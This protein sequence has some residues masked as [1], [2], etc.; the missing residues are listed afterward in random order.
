MKLSI[1]VLLCLFL[2]PAL[3]NAQGGWIRQYY[4]NLT[5]LHKI[6][7]APNGDNF[8]SGIDYR[9]GIPAHF[10][11][12][13]HDADGNLLWEKSHRLS[14]QNGFFNFFLTA[15]PLNGFVT[16][17]AMTVE[18]GNLN[19]NTAAMIAVNDNGDTLWSYVPTPN[20]ESYIF[21]AVYDTD[22]N[23]VV[24]SSIRSS[25]DLVLRPIITK[26]NAQNGEIIWTK[27]INE[28]CNQGSM[29]IQKMPNGFAISWFGSNNYH[30]VAFNTDGDE[31]WH[32]IF[33]LEYDFNVK[34]EG[35]FRLFRYAVA[36]SLQIIEYDLNGN[37]TKEGVAQ[38]PYITLSIPVDS[39]FVV[40]GETQ[41]SL[42]LKQFNADYQ[43]VN[44]LSILENFQS[45]I[46]MGQSLKDGYEMP[47][48][49]FTLLLGT[50]LLRI[51][52]N[53]TLQP[54]TLTGKIF[55]DKSNDC[56]E[57][58]GEL[59]LKNSIVTAKNLTDGLVWATTTDSA[60]VY[61]LKLT[62]GNFEINAVA[63]FPKIGYW[64]NCPPITISSDLVGDTTLLDPIGL[65]T[66]VDCPL[67]NVQMC[68]GLFRPCSTSVVTLKVLNE[69]TLVENQ[70]MVTLSHSPLLTYESS[71]IPL[72]NQ[73]GNTLF[74]DI[75][76][77][78]SLSDTSFNVNFFVDC[79]AQLG[80]TACLT[81]SVTPD[82]LCIEPENWDGA[83]LQITSY[84]E[85]DTVK[86]LV[87]NKG[88]GG[89][90]EVSELI[91]IEDYIIFR[92]SP[93]QLGSGQD[94][95]ITQPNPDGKTYYASI[96]QTDNFPG[97]IIASAGEDYCGGGGIPG[98]L[99]NYPML[100]GSPF[101]TRYCGEIS[102]AFD[103]NDK[104]GFPLGYGNS[105]YIDRGI[106]IDYRI[107]FQ[108]TG[109]DTA[110]T[111]IV[112]D[113]LPTTLDVTTLRIGASSHPFTWEFTGQST[114]KFRFDHILLPDSTTNEP[115]SHGFV[116]FKISPKTEIP[117]GTLIE[118]R[119]AIYFDYNVPVFTDFARHTVD[120]NFV[121]VAFKEVLENEN[122]LEVYPNPATDLAHI[123][124]FQ[125][126]KGFGN[127]K[128][129]LNDVYGVSVLEQKIQ[130][131]GAEIRRNGL[132]SGVYF[133]EI[134]DGERVVGVRKVLFL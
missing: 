62:P 29:K 118:N 2:F 14:G 43:L 64:Q 10:L 127:L 82:S 128:L 89:M 39:G 44:D 12:V 58:N 117:N 5:T 65:K 45:P 63:S 36:D 94:T 11:V 21:G 99:L 3:S 113:T 98:L 93:L 1:K 8:L 6:A 66:V 87:K 51:E 30:F 42:F 56:L 134:L 102:T 91:I 119:A 55:N 28:S 97:E 129:R 34:K 32:K 125:N 23:L 132:A 114:L 53:G 104:Q 48:G 78:N 40:L 52:A 101:T 50:Y 107:R 81:A 124:G 133:L 83:D 131:N 69:G 13:R 75:G 33:N 86:F 60:G 123:V 105:N 49:S 76:T 120:S 68:A 9:D 115:A 92:L 16:G 19:I 130:E 96:R 70:T 126:I 110:F 17:G 77:L 24:Y 46:L 18:S 100:D 15:S 116:Q 80:Q 95:L 37:L 88:L 54:T 25:L 84:C 109:N 106:D 59:P 26:L 38:S 47:D 4:A 20:S 74:F 61:F 79:S 67:L 27:N 7:L 111:I 35:G 103:P 85:N 31:I 22:G 108:N 71:S 72:I 73:V 41:N 122:I 57:N 112:L 90:N 121:L